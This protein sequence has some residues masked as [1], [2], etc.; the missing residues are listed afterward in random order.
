MLLHRAVVVWGKKG[1]NRKM[2]PDPHITRFDSASS[3]IVKD[4]NI[5]GAE[6]HND[7]ADGASS[8]MES[9][10]QEQENVGE[11]EK[12]KNNNNFSSNKK[13]DS[14]GKK[15]SQRKQQLNM[16]FLN[17]LLSNEPYLQIQ[18]HLCCKMLFGVGGVAKRLKL[19]FAR[20]PFLGVL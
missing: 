18:I 12:G 6:L 5:I 17:K 3:A 20:T 7:V 1:P 8:S 14:Y 9:S 15:E 10:K 2:V 13:T 4:D 11:Q 19:H 16:Y